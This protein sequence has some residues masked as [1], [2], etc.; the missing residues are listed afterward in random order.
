M[1]QISTVEPKYK[2]GEVDEEIISDARNAGLSPIGITSLEVG[3]VHTYKRALD[4]LAHD[5]PGNIWA[6]TTG[7]ALWF[8]SI[9]DC[10]RDTEYHRITTELSRLI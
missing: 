9:G 1:K 10:A 7:Y 8:N 4:A 6:Y 3:N 2:V 5:N